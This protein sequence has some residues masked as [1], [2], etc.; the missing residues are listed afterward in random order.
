VSGASWSLHLPKLKPGRY[1]IL[2]RATDRAGHPS[3]TVAKTVQLE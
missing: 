2:V 3:A 1:T